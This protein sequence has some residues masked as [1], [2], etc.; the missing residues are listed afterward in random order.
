MKVDRAPPIVPP[1][2]ETGRAENEIDSRPPGVDSYRESAGAGQFV[3]RQRNLCS[4]TR[5][6]ARKERASGPFGHRQ[7]SDHSCCR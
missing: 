3:G 7:E 6:T 2:G 4:T 1:E 5:R